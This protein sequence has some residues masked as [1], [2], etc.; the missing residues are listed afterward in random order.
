MY[1]IKVKATLTIAVSDTKSQLV[2][3]LFNADAN[4][5][6]LEQETDGWQL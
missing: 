1:C 5:I 2:F 4:K 3:Q 6:Q